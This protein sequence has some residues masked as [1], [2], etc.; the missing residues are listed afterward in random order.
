MTGTRSRIR[1]LLDAITR[2]GGLKSR[3]DCQEPSEALRMRSPERLGVD[4]SRYLVENELGVDS[5]WRDVL[6]GLAPFHDCA[7]RLRV[8]PIEL[9]DFASKDL[10]EETREL[11]RRFARRSDINLKSFAWTLESTPDGPCYVSHLGSGDIGAR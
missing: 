5:D 11:A 2:G 10:N 1:T 7:L 6:V 9:F 3:T 4:L 8:D